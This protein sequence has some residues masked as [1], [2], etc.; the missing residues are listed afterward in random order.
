M[1]IIEFYGLP[2]SGKS[3]VCERVIKELRSGG[4]QVGDID[5]YLKYCKGIKWVMRGLVSRN[6]FTFFSTALRTLRRKKM[7]FCRDVIVRILRV[8]QFYAYYDMCVKQK[9]YTYMLMDQAIIQGYISTFY[10]YT[11]MTAGDYRCV[12]KGISSYNFMSFYMDISPETASERIDMRGE[13]DHG[14]CDKIK[15]ITSRIRILEV[16]AKN[17]DCGHSVFS[18][19][20]SSYKVDANLDIDEK[21]WFVLQKINKGFKRELK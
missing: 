6:G 20:H 15:D 4:N 18:N 3:T 7:L 1:Q 10:D 9:K 5:E 14:R 19:T 17:F 16:Q 11:D 12:V 21:V 13:E 8:L 2:G